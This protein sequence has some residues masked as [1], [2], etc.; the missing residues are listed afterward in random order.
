MKKSCCLGIRRWKVRLQS[1]LFVLLKSVL[2]HGYETVM[3]SIC[4]LK[5]DTKT[6]K[7]TVVYGIQLGMTD[8][9]HAILVSS[10][11]QP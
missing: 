2:G 5:I 8:D 1:Q 11:T 3:M 6:L 10:Y 4:Y 7:K 9:N